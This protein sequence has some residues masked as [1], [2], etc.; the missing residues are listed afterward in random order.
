M[1]RVNMI[2][3]LLPKSWSVKFS[4]KHTYVDWR[5]LQGQCVFG[6]Q[7]GGDGDDDGY[8]VTLHQGVANCLSWFHLGA[9]QINHCFNPF[10]SIL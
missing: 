5:G 3:F 8:G 4:S 7:S 10:F 1:K 6:E 2:C 9:K